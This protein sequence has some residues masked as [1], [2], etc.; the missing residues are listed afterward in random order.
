MA[1]ANIYVNFQFR[2]NPYPELMSAFCP[3]LSLSVSG[4][5]CKRSHLGVIFVC[6]MPWRPKPHA[7]KLPIVFA[8][9]IPTARNV[10][11]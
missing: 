10:S 1:P 2:S 8:A 6:L 7:A 3:K 4:D 9:P 11:G 5:G